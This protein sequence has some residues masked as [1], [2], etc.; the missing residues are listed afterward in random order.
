ML[1]RI[2]NFIRYIVLS[3][4]AVFLFCGSYYVLSDSFPNDGDNGDGVGFHNLPKNSLDVLVI[5][6][7]H[8]QYSFNPAFFYQDTGLYSYVL[9]SACQPLNISYRMLKEALKTQKPKAVIQEVFTAMPLKETCEGISCLIIPS[10]MMTGQERY[11]TIKSL[12]QD[13]Q[14]LYLNPFIA[15]HNEWK[16]DD[17]TYDDIY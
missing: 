17:I 4:L 5:G 13:K 11:D 3:A 12:P 16:N 14:D 6:S 7:S 1:K 8:A 9:G 15:T 10:F 2:V